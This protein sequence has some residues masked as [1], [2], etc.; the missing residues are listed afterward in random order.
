MSKTK[1]GLALF[2]GLLL[3]GVLGTLAGLLLAPQEGKKTRAEV[4][5][6][7]DKI[8]KEGMKALDKL[9]DRDL[10]P[11]LR[12]L[13]AQLKTNAKSFAEIAS[14][15]IKQLRKEVL[16]KAKQAKSKSSK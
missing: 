16:A 13:R 8:Q 11:I 4:K 2:S 9:K 1:T 7:L 5:V 14:K 15:E 12:K 6:K 3:G 10:E